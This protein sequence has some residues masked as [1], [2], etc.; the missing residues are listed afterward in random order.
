MKTDLHVNIAAMDL[1]HDQ[2][3]ELLNRIQISSKNEFLPLFEEM[4]EHTKEHFAYEEAL[5]YK[6]DFYGKY[7]H[8]DEHTTLLAEMNY[9]YE[10]ARQMTLFGKAYINEYA[11]EKFKRHIINID[12]QLAMFFK[13]NNIVLEAE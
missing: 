13:E 5:M 6:Y 10:K 2:F 4:I 9:F 11:Y 12:S 3:L 7:E 8:M 1:K